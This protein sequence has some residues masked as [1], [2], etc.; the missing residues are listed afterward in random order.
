VTGDRIADDQHSTI[1]VAD[2]KKWIVFLGLAV[3]CLCGLARAADVPLGPGDTVRVTIYGDT[4]PPTDTRV[5]ESGKITVPL[6]GEVSVTGL[7]T[8]DAERKIAGL[9][10][11]KGFM[12]DPQVNVLVTSPVSQQVAVLGQVTKP[13]RYVLDGARTVTDMVATAGGVTPDGGDIV[14]LVRTR[15]GKTERSQIDLWALS[16][17]GDQSS[18]VVMQRDDVLVVERAQKFYVYGEVQRPGMYR[19]E[20]GMSVLQGLSAGGGLTPRGTENGMRIKRRDENGK[21]VEMKV[22]DD[23][24]LL[25]PDDILY[26]RE[27]WF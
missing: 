13:G 16:N 26:I 20:H 8:T 14:T 12:R 6:I 1:K 15:D 19:L 23:A 9:L 5:T 17:G 25:Q 27:S 4:N 10:Q 3:M 11:Q 24:T 22:N 18:N 2:M 21:L 7:S